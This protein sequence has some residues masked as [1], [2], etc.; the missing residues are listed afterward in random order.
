[1]DA[2]SLSWTTFSTVGYGLVFPGTSATAMNTR[3]CTGITIVTTAESFFGI[4][5]ASFWGAIF[6]AKVTRVASHAQV[7][8]SDAIIVKYGTGIVGVDPK[9][10]DDS[11]E[12]GPS[13]PQRPPS[14]I[15]GESYGSNAQSMGAPEVDVN[16]FRYKRSTLPCPFLEFRV[17]NRLHSQRGGEIIDASMNIVASIDEEQAALALRNAAKSQPRRR[18]RKGKRR[19]RV[20][21]KS[22]A[23]VDDETDLTDEASIRRLQE[24]AQSVVDS[25]KKATEMEED[26]TGRLLP[27][28]IFAKLEVNSMEHPFFKR[29][30]I[31]RH[32]LDH[33]SPLLKQEAK[34]LVRLNGGHWPL[35]L[36]SAD[37]VRASFHFDQ[38]LV[39]LSGTSNVD[40]NNVY[41]QK[42]YDFVDVCVGYSFC[43]MLFRQDDGSIGVDP[44]LLNDVKEQ[45]GGGGEDLNKKEDREVPI[46]IL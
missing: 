35:E 14:H 18:G 23:D 11:E 27:K 44:T 37:A 2:Y 30:W 20:S 41:A 39:S 45:I 40:A 1:M 29:V 6:F 42:V 13:S 38:I 15:G 25:H 4:L 22:R 12:E 21:T 26:P 33:N 7:L 43:N 19:S 46:F 9:H 31:V 3:Q 24:S 17:V 36:N 34:E 8:F 5:F 28:R 32:I 16:V 10:D